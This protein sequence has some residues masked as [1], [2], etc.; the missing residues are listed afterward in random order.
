MGTGYKNRNSIPHGEHSVRYPLEV[1]QAAYDE[2]R[3]RIFCEAT[4]YVRR[5]RSRFQDR[6]QEKN[7]VCA[8]IKATAS[9]DKRVF[10]S[11]EIHGHPLVG[12]LDTGASF[13]RQEEPDIPSR[14]VEVSMGYKQGIRDITLYVC[15]TVQQPLY[16]GVD[17]WRKFQLAPEILGVESIEPVEPHILNPQQQQKLKE[18]SS[19]SR[20]RDWRWSI[21]NRSEED[22]SNQPNPGAQNSSAAAKFPG[23]GRMVSAVHP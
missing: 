4:Q 22:R 17:F 20:I 18:I 13:N 9:G 2:A 1:R 5:A 3:A 14:K 15:P 7:L 12:L 19:V 16:L 8:A 10:A 11:V 23:Y 6:R 21:E